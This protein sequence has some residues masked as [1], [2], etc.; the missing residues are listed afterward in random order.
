M[1]MQWD[2]KSV[3]EVLGDKLIGTVFMRE[4]VC[5]TLLILP[6]DIIERVCKTVWFISSQEDAWAFTFKGS[7]IKERHLVFL[8]DVLLKQDENQIRYTI[9]HEVGH[10]VLNHSN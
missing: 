6:P 3:R 7:D 5:K 4:Q 2:I 10:V 8:S 1:Q 9:L